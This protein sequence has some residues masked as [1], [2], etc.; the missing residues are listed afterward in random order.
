MASIAKEPNGRRRIQ[1]TG[2][3]GA[4]RTI[5]LG[6]IS[7]KGAECVLRHVE[8][9][10][11]AKLAA[12]PIPRDTAAWLTEIGPTLRDR[13]AAV[14]LIDAE[15]RVNLGPFLNEYILSRADVK[16]AT[17][18]VWQQ[19]VRNLVGFFGADRPLRAVTPGDAERFKQ[20]LATQ[21]LAVATQAKRLSF[22]RTFFHVARKHR[23]IDENP[24]AEVKP[25]R[26]DVSRRQ[27]FVPREVID[28]LM[29]VAD[30]T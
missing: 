20:W 18:E 10:L 28:R 6:K 19:P 16:P 27:Q 3:D 11:G 7:A 15:K 29:A 21:G 25:P 13:L 23:L 26:A 8:R 24:F 22:A 30:P 5:R 1:F 4:R 9:L 17:L 12:Q 14:G 2:E